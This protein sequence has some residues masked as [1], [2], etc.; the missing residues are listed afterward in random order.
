MRIHYKIFDKYRENG[1]SWIAIS[2]E[3][4][5]LEVK[6]YIT[7]HPTNATVLLNN[8]LIKAEYELEAY[9][10]F[11]LI[12]R[13]GKIVLISLGAR[14]VKDFDKVV[15]QYLY[16]TPGMDIPGDQ[17]FQTAPQTS[18]ILPFRY[19]GYSIFSLNSL[20]YSLNLNY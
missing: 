3:T 15:A 13:D 2:R 10:S 16:Q 19:I 8:D 12:D 18:P 5:S 7:A 4:D 17:S 14:L 9:P 6:K 1:Y 11:Y 20:D